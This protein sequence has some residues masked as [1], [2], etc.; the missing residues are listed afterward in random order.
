MDSKILLVFLALVVVASGC[1]YL[2]R[3]TPEQQYRELSQ[4]AESSTYHVTYDISVGG[5]DAL[6]SMI[7]DP[8]L[9]SYEGKTKMVM[10]A[11]FMGMSSTTAVYSFGNRSVTCK[12]GAS[13]LGDSGISC[14]LGDSG[15]ETVSLTDM[16]E[17]YEDDLDRVDIEVTGTRKIA[18]RT[19]KMFSMKVPADVL[20]SSQYDSGAEMGVCLDTE[21]GYVAD[22][23]MN[24]TKQSELAGNTSQNVLRMTVKSYDDQ[25]SASDVEI[26]VKASV[27]LEYRCDP[28]EAEIV[29]FSSISDAELS[30]NGQNRTL[31]LEAGERR[32]VQLDEASK[33]DGENEVVLYADGKSSATCTDYGFGFDSD[34]DTG[35]E[36][37]YNYSYDQ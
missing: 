15:S 25:V 28:F 20:N 18:G 14:E 21:K 32:T 26:P 33:V 36:Y 7:G 23:G 24:I 6:T 30:V 37:D 2:E 10:T 22:M 34:Y 17:E 31:N 35:S 9:Y 8:E 27:D 12:D 29:S 16:N 5:S 11:N 19:C 13:I 3:S 1:S 4:K